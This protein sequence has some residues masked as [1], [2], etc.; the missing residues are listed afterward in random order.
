MA[1]MPDI[2]WISSGASAEGASAALAGR[3]GADYRGSVNSAGG[4][5]AAAAAAQAY[6][7]ARAEET[8]AI[9]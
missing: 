6:E 8:A 3:H 2:A 9:G 7:A 1:A 5:P 4:A